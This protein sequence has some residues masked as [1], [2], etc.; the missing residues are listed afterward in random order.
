MPVLTA[1]EVLTLVILRVR[2]KY[3]RCREK[4]RNT[5]S[6]IGQQAGLLTIIFSCMCANCLSSQHRKIYFRSQRYCKIEKAVPIMKV[7]GN[8]KFARA[9][10]QSCVNYLL[11]WVLP[12]QTNQATF[13]SIVAWQSRFSGPGKIRKDGKLT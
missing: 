4:F 5:L 11:L 6:K 10:N 7:F 12:V 8:L 13:V 3:N 9:R 1:L 2:V